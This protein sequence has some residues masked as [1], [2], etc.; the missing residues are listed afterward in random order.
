MMNHS[1]LKPTEAPSLGVTISSPE[2]TMVAVMM[3]PG[4]RWRTSAP[5]VVGGALV[6]VD[7][8]LS[9]ADLDV[10]QNDGFPQRRHR[11]AQRDELVREVAGIAGVLDRL[12]D[13]GPLQLLRRVELVSAG[14]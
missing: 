4:P 5:K 12:H 3:K 14:H 9:I 13:R 7:Y 6:I 2:P 11:V 1:R 10:T 8:G